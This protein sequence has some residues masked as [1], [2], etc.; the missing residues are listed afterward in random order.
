MFISNTVCTMNV[1]KKL[2]IR[3]AGMNSS[4]YKKMKCEGFE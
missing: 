3:Y 4:W 1:L 2:K